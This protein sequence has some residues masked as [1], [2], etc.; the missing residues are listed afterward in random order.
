MSIATKNTR[1]RK[2]LKNAVVKVKEPLTQQKHD[3]G[4]VLK[5]AP[6]PVLNKIK[7][8]VKTIGKAKLIRSL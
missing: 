1:F 5:D 6:Q 3:G 4:L 2:P 8:E 7:S